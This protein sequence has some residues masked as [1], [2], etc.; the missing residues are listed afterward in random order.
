MSLTSKNRRSFSKRSE[1]GYG[2]P[3]EHYSPECVEEGFSEVRGLL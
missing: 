1:D 3:E 2:A